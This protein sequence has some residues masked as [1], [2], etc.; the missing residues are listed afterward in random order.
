M[1]Q[2]KPEDSGL[3]VVFMSPGPSVSLSEFHE[4][5]DTEHVPLRIQRFGTFRSACRYAVTSTA[6]HPPT[7]E[8]TGEWAAVYTIS[9][10]AVFAQEGYTRL[11]SERSAREAE[12]FTRLA[13]V[14]RRIY[15][16]EYDSDL[17]ANIDV[18]RLKLG[19]DV[20]KAKDTP[21]YLVTNS[22][23]MKPE[24]QDEY[25]RWFEQEHVPMLSK[26][27]G[28]K[29]S[30]RFTLIDNGINGTQAKPG[31]ADNVPGCLGLHGTSFRPP[32]STAATYCK[33]N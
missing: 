14:D 4:W 10:N 33:R 2:F 27:R 7:A 26:V 21:G 6:L 12:L 23:E 32:D 28:W 15:R 31:M 8:A 9:S 18:E 5:Y 25:N 19:L 22:V 30:R 1:T 11:R 20:Q 13:L 16:L 29:R 3:L 17:D 24:M